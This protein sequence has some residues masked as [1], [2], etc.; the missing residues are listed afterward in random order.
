M[1]QHINKCCQSWES[2]GL[3]LA[4]Q[5]LQPPSTCVTW[6]GIEV[7]TAS[8]ELRI[9]PDR[10]EATISLLRSWRK[11]DSCTKTELQSILG[12]LHFISKCCKPARLFVNRMLE[13]LRN[14]NAHGYTQHVPLD[15]EFQKDINWFIDFLPSFNG[16]SVIRDKRIDYTA[17]VDSCLTGCGALCQNE[18]YHEI[19]PDFIQTESHPIAHLEMLNL[20]LAAKVWAKKWAGHR[21]LFLCDNMV[22]VSVLA[23]GR[24][25]DHFLMACAREIW[26]Q[27]ALYDW[28]LVAEHRSAECM[29]TAD[30]LSRAHLSEHFVKKFAHLPSTGRIHIDARLF[31]LTSSY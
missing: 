16:K 13:T 24:A 4:K 12:K 10:I 22:S 5:K 14:A 18:F 25:R 21:V 8:M 2:L 26:L 27:T 3:P 9:P 28:E 17:E 19:F 6:L 29:Q 7:D 1:S 31:K 11:K 20:V 15:S 23:T 30:A